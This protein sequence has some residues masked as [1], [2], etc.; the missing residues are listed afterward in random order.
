MT[1]PIEAALAHAL[2]QYDP[3]QTPNAEPLTIAAVRQLAQQHGLSPR[4]VEIAALRCGIVP[5]RYRRNVGTVGWEGQ[6]ALLQAHVAVVG[7]GGLGGWVIETL[8]RMGVGQLAIYD[9]DVFQEN[10]LNRQ[11]GCTEA[12]LGRPKAQVLA[13]RVAQVNSAVTVTPYRT[14]LSEANAATLLQGADVVVDALDTLPAR[15]VVQ[16]AAATL[17]IPLVHGAIAG[18]TGQVMTI[19]PGDPGLEALYGP[20]PHPERGVEVALGNPSATPMMIASWQAQQVVKIITGAQEGL[21][22]MRLLLLDAQA[23]DATVIRLGE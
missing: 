12:T 17:G 22:R 4:E 20:G 16:N 3:H 7:A 2:R 21:L 14:Y 1:Q 23:G 9:G 10:N 6:I 8:A 5:E 19:L 18:Y 15:F 13:E 11:L